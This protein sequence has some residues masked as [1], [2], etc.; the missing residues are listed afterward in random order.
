MWTALLAHWTIVR[1]S[2]PRLP[3]AVAKG[4]YT[5]AAPAALGAA[6]CAFEPSGAVYSFIYRRNRQAQTSSLAVI[7]ENFAVIHYDYQRDYACDV[8]S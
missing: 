8:L 4:I 7:S 3:I 5:P 2:I 1:L 6:Q